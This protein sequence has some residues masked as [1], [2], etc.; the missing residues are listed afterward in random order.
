VSAWLHV[1]LQIGAAKELFR[2]DLVHFLIIKAGWK[3]FLPCLNYFSKK[4]LFC[5]NCIVNSDVTVL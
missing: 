3:R 2:S 5:L 4:K 1:D